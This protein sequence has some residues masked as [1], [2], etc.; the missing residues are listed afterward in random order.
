MNLNKII[1]SLFF[2]IFLLTA[3]TSFS[4][5]PQ[6]DAPAKK[7]ISK[8]LKKSSKMTLAPSSKVQRKTITE[9][10]NK[11]LPAQLKKATKK[12]TRLYSSKSRIERAKMDLS[13]KKASGKIS[14]KEALK[15]E[16]RIKES[17]DQLSKKS[18]N[19]SSFSK[20]LDHIKPVIEN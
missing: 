18:K 13:K 6:K 11:Y 19:T 2:L 16:S 17:E 3:N 4:Q 5:T 1:T 14:K 7:E 20:K 8:P 15:E 10:N 12:N 9:K